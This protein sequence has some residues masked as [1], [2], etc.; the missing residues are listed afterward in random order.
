M[1]PYVPAWPEGL[2]SLAVRAVGTLMITVFY[3][4]TLLVR[5]GAEAWV[6][7]RA[8]SPLPAIQ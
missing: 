1:A 3:K 8:A 5:E 2:I 6:E 4:I 7:E